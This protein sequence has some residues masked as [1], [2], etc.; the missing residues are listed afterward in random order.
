MYAKTDSELETAQTE[1]F[2]DENDSDDDDDPC[3]RYR[4]RVRPWQTTVG[5]QGWHVS[6]KGGLNHGFSNLALNGVLC[7][8]SVF[9]SAATTQ[10][11][12]PKQL[13]AS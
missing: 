6:N 10:T 13:C 4:E 7:I 2:S 9:S 12:T 1:F 5:K 11:T 8:D 3:D